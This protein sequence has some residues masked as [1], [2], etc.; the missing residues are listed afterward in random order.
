[1]LHRNQTAAINMVQVWMTLV[2]KATKT[3]QQISIICSR[4]IPTL[5]NNCSSL[6]LICK[7]NKNKIQIKEPIVVASSVDKGNQNQT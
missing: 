7:V 6:R 5:K 2:E 1:M 4:T 3:A